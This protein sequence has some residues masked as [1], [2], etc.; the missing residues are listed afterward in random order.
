MSKF[1]CNFLEYYFYCCN[2]RTVV[3]IFQDSINW[4][5]EKGN[6][7][8]APKPP[9]LYALKILRKRTLN[10]GDHFA[11]VGSPSVAA[12]EKTTPCIPNCSRCKTSVQLRSGWSC[13]CCE[14]AISSTLLPV[15]RV[16]FNNPKC[17]HAVVKHRHEK[18]KIKK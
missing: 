6:T 2:F 3:L 7:S 4:N 1:T 8:N 13:C 5:H 16:A 17:F 11:L 9:F 10:Y 14:R 15:K 12:I 18:L